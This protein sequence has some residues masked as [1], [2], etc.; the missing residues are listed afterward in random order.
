MHLPTPAYSR[1]HVCVQ[2]R[3]SVCLFVGALTG[4]RLELSKP[5]LVLVYSITVARQRSKG[6]RSRSH[7]YQNRH[8][9]IW[10]LVTCA[11]TAYA[12]V[13]THVD[14]IAYVF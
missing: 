13:G 12:G 8:G 11:A 9:R 6:Q 3:L 5:N 2:S 10:L 4:K 1:R 7:G 14:T